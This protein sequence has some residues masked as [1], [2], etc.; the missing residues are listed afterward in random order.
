MTRNHVHDE[1]DPY[2]DGDD[3]GRDFRH[4]D[5]RNLRKWRRNLIEPRYGYVLL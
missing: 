5:F 4:Y 1:L 2:F 3:D